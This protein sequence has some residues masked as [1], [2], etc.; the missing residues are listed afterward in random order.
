MVIR[1]G[2]WGLLMV[3]SLG[4]S[5]THD[6]RRFT[7][8]TGVESKAEHP[9]WPRAPELPRYLYAGEL[10]GEEN[11]PRVGAEEPGRAQ[12][13]FAWLVGLGQERREPV[14]L[15]RPLGGTVDG[16]GRVYV[17]DVSRQ[18]V[19]RFDPVT[20]GLDVWQ[21]AAP[22]QRFRSPIAVAMGPGDEVLVTDAELHRVYRLG[23]DGAPRG[24]IGADQL[25][26]PTGIARDGPRGE[27]YVADT[28]AHDIKVFDDAGGL[29][30]RIGHEGREEGALNAPTY[31]AFRDDRLYVTDTLNARIQVFSR[32]GEPLNTI[33]ERGLF[34]GNLVIPKGVSVDD[35]GHVYV[36]ESY[37]DH[38]LVFDSDGR[39]LLPIGGSGKESGQ[40]YLPA[41][42]WTDP[43]GRVYVADMFNGRVEVFQFLGDLQ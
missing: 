19:Y 6:V 12:R 25:R 8:D 27:I 37:Y 11:F 41:G 5:A 32:E 40:F 15:Q 16:A 31:I 38:L 33:G 14:V 20:P 1:R 22:G 34:V 17:T 42:V 26:R 35:E 21:E 10:T 18:A 29:V 28:E 2:L 24:E 39:F 30:R 7:L 13:F 3:L 4:C 23:P 9:V 36:V 43:N